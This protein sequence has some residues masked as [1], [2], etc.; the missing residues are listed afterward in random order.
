MNFCRASENILLSFSAT[1]SHEK[2]HK[3]W[4]ERSSRVRC[5]MLD[6]WYLSRPS[7]REPAKKEMHWRCHNF[8]I[9]FSEPEILE[10]DRAVQ[11]RSSTS[12]LTFLLISKVTENC[13]NSNT[14][15]FWWSDYGKQRKLTTYMILWRRSVLIFESTNHTCVHCNCSTTDNEGDDENG[16]HGVCCLSIRVVSGVS[17][18]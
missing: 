13:Y 2:D 12:S 1:Y 9:E 6:R 4:S 16:F 15:L 5:S 7:R 18:K 14:V 11:K 17:L 3:P 10:I 8:W